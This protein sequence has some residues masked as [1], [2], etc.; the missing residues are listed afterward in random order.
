[1][2]YCW[3]NVLQN[4]WNGTHGEI[5]TASCLGKSKRF[6]ATYLSIVERLKRE[7]EKCHWEL[8]ERLHYTCKL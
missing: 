6:Q 4:D 2:T 5:P 7:Q 3:P 1:M 8:G